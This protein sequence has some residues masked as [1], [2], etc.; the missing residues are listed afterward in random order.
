MAAKGTPFFIEPE[1]LSGEG[2]ELLGGLRAVDGILEMLAKLRDGTSLAQERVFLDEVAKAIETF[3][4]CIKEELAAVAVQDR[5][6]EFVPTNT[7]TDTR[8]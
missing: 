2:R 4:E 1:K 5:G 3:G 8:Q 7:G 6:G